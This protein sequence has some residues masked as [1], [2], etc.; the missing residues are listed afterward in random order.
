MCA[1]FKDLS[2]TINTSSNIDQLMCKYTIGHYKLITLVLQGN[3]RHALLMGTP[4]DPKELDCLRDN[5]LGTLRLV[6]FH[7]LFKVHRA[8][9]NEQAESAV[10]K[11]ATK[12]RS[13][14]HHS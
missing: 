1:P 3:L 2:N 5:V 11:N 8:W 14:H 9:V 7:V 10:I 4:T 13:F 6:L 12:A